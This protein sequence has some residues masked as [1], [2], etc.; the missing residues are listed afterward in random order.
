[1]TEKEIDN[2]NNYTDKEI[3]NQEENFDQNFVQSEDRCSDKE[4]ECAPEEDIQA[5]GGSQ[6][7]D[8]LEEEKAKSEE[9][10]NQMLRLQAE[11]E[12]YRK[13][14]AKEKEDLLKYGS[15]QLIIKLLPVLDNFDIA[16]ES[17]KDSEDKKLFEGI[18]MI[19]DQIHDTLE[20]EGMEIIPTVGE[21]FD[22]EIHEAVIREE[23]EEHSENTVT[24]ELRRGYSFN[25]K[26]IRAAMVKVA[27]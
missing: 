20:K 16:L 26:V 14:V 24:M 12:N 1:M 7:S 23:S 15:E 9:Y 5:S 6:L 8:L 4:P 17:Q 10:Y 13:R 3:E 21:P 27:G 22:P 19:V 11:F 2:E 25:G 18:Q